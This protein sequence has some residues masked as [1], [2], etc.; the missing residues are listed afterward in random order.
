MVKTSV[1]NM[2]Y[3]KSLWTLLTGNRASCEQW[4]TCIAPSGLQY[5]CRE[6]YVT[7]D[8]VILKRHGDFWGAVRDTV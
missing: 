2:K 3:L 6:K 8:C 7:A 5:T 1:N 4:V